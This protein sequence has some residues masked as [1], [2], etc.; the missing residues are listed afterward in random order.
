MIKDSTEDQIDLYHKSLSNFAKHNLN[1]IILPY[2]LEYS[3]DKLHGGLIGEIDNNNNVVMDAPRGLILNS[4]VLWTY[5]AC[6][7]LL[8]EER[9]L[10]RAKST[11][12]YL[13]QKFYDPQHQGFYWSLDAKGNALDSKKQ[14]YAQ[15]FTMYGLSEYYSV[16]SDPLALKMAIDLF[17]LM[18][19]NCLDTLYGG[20]FEAFTREWK[21]IEDMRL[22]QKDMNVEKTMNTHLHVIEAYTCLHR[23]WKD[24]TLEN[25]IRSLLD[26]FDQYFVNKKDYHLNLFFDTQWNLMSDQISYGH[27]IEA[28]WL[29]HESAVELGDKKLE[30]VFE[31]IAVR[32]ADAA[33]EGIIEQGSLIH[34]WHRGGDGEKDDEIEWWAQAEAVVGF[35]NAYEIS[36]D[37]RFLITAHNLCEFIAKYI[38][39]KEF[40]EWH[41][42]VSKEGVPNNTYPIAGFWKCPYHNARMCLEI[43][44]RSEEQLA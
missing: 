11:F 39:N 21:P 12:E 26:V 7:K 31:E 4:R 32:M 14:T 19:K 41:Y 34:E 23:V 6:Y 1:K 8:K 38:V 3:P 40:G 33:M 29:L 44:T 16:S 18:E 25:A 37:T 27:D 24:K 13:I 22:S 28:S 20:Y 30:G 10:E 2:W 42:R 17:H 15:A 36:K 9:L 43:I 35:F 5:S